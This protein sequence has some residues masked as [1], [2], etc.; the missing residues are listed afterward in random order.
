[1]IAL[2]LMIIQPS[3][4]FVVVKGIGCL[5]TPYLYYCNKLLP[6]DASYFLQTASFFVPQ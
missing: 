5:E 1:M 4:L 3:T 2:I 6:S